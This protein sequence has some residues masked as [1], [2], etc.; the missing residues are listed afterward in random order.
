MQHAFYALLRDSREAGQT[1]L[2]S[3]HLLPEVQE[4]CGRAAF[5]RAGRLVAVE[6]MSALGT[7]AVHEVE[8]VLARDDAG[9]AAEALAALAGVSAVSP[10]GAGVRCRVA[11][12]MDPVVKLLARYDVLAVR[13]AEPDLDDLFMSYYGEDPPQEA[14][15][16]G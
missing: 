14:G 3:S 12:S 7:R 5:V 9:P 8:V 11:G 16:A 2:L 4:V 15:D 13:S 10:E 1:V 6:D